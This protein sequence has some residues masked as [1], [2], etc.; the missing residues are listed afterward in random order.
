MNRKNIDHCIEAIC[1]KGCDEVL[2][3][4]HSMERGETPPDAAHLDPDERQ[5]VQRELQ[6]IMAVYGRF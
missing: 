5:A 2:N 1:Q 4:I 3:T 6:A